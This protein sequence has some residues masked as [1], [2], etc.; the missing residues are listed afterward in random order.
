V[1]RFLD[2]LI[3]VSVFLIIM[4]SFLD[5]LISRSVFLLLNLGLVSIP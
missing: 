2:L 5:L 1:L 3:L 4:V